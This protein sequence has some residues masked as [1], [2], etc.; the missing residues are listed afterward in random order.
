MKHLFR[1]PKTFLLL[2]LMV[3]TS[4]CTIFTCRIGGREV[5]SFNWDPYTDTFFWRVYIGEGGSAT[6]YSYIDEPGGSPVAG[7]LLSSLIAVDIV[8]QY[9]ALIASTLG[10]YVETDDSIYA[11]NSD[12]TQAQAIA[13]DTT[14]SSGLQPRALRVTSGLQTLRLSPDGKL[15]YATSRT[16]TR[17][18]AVDLASRTLAWSVDLGAGAK[19]FGIAVAVDSSRVYVTDSASNAIYSVDPAAQTFRTFANP[20]NGAGKP[21]TSPDG[22]QLWVPNRASGNITVFD[23]LSET[24][25]TTIDKVANASELAFNP[26]GTRAFAINAPQNGG[27]ALLTYDP[28]N[29]Q[30][31]G[32]LN[33]GPGPNGMTFSPGGTLLY[34]ANSGNGTITVVDVRSRPPVI[35][36]TLRSGPRPTSV[37]VFVKP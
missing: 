1:T 10:I 31:I 18:Y 36:N 7:P 30:S 32:S 28:T 35:A 14:V 11:L 33:L 6:G 27:G 24:L 29:Y 20:G 17:L 22:T 2:L 19:P 21:A 15:G 4:A 16:S 8:C 12:G 25:T 13:G 23:I 3:F 34:I 5:F 9:N 26:S 37:A